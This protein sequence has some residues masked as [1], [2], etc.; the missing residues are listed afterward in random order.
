MESLI[1]SEALLK[2]YQNIYTVSECLPAVSLCTLCSA[3][4]TPALHPAYPDSS[5]GPHHNSSTTDCCM[6]CARFVFLF[7]WA[8]RVLRFS[9]HSEAVFEQ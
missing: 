6:Y 1:C 5:L 7:F 2:I 3:L 4:S 9:I 8:S